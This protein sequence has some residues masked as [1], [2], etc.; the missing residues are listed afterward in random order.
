MSL[1]IWEDIV[2]PIIK[3]VFDTID[4]LIPDKTKAEELKTEVQVTAMNQDFSKFENLINKQAAVIM[5]E[6]QGKSWIERDWRAIA[7]L[8]FVLVVIYNYV[9]APM[10][11]L[12][13]V[14][15]VHDMWDLL[16][17]GIGGY[18]V[19]TSVENSVASWKGKGKTS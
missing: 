19:G 17:I 11:S 16:K 9:F 15:I 10:F 2:S 3:P 13:S 18:V 8:S 14:V 6:T 12:P 7:M 5:S 1:N 4:R